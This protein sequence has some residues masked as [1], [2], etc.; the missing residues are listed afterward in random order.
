MIHRTGH[1]SPDGSTLTVRFRRAE[2]ALT[3]AAGAAVTVTLT[4]SITGGVLEGSDVVR[5]NTTTIHH[6]HAGDELAPGTTL[7]VDWDKSVAAAPTV[8]ILAS[9]DDGETWELIANELENTGSFAWT[10]PNWSTTTARLAVVQIEST[11]PGD[12]TGFR[13]DRRAGN[14]RGVSPSRARFR[15]PVPVAAFALRPLGN[16]VTGPLRVACSL[17]SAEPAML[18][19]FDVTGRLCAARRL[20]GVGSAEHHTRRARGAGA[21]HRPAR[22]A[23][24]QSLLTRRGRPLI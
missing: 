13:G 10:V 8:A 15:S 2:L 16:P 21:L 5:V 7:T 11:D 23:G 18:Q 1:V 6:P 9:K 3:P 22:A 24:P 4:G 20:D 17:P 12:P 19:L 14:H